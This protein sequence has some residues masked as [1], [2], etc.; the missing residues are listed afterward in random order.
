MHHGLDD[1]FES[2]RLNLSPTPLDLSL[3]CG[4]VHV[5]TPSQRRHAESPSVQ[6]LY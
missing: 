3:Y 6:E 4:V 5:E 1:V 2:L